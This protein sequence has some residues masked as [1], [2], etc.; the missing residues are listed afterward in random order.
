MKIYLRA[1]YAKIYIY[2]KLNLLKLINIYEEEY[3]PFTVA[4]IRELC[5]IWLRH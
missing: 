1:L 2:T 3:R 5:T 4:S